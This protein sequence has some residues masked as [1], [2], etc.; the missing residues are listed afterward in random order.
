MRS[1]SEDFSRLVDYQDAY[2]EGARRYD[3]GER[4]NF[5]LVPMVNA[6]LDQLLAWG[7]GEIASSLRSINACIEEIATEAGFRA[8]PPER[9]AP[10]ILG[11]T[12]EGGLPDGLLVG[13]RESGVHI[14]IRGSALRV[15]P[16]LHVNDADL[17]RFR[18]ALR[19]LS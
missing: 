17:D 12:R 13:F 1:G 19:K 2:R 4:S 6:G 18:A 8:L 9:R 3:V 14:G 10:H 7:V 11:L 15:A 16:H 5:A